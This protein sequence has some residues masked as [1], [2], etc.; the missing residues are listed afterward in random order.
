MTDDEIFREWLITIG[1]PEDVDIEKYA[2]L[3]DTTNFALYR[4][5]EIFWSRN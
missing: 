5:C 4:L 2:E 1:Y 3:K